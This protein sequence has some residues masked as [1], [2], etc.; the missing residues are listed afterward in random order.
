MAC[1]QVDDFMLA[2]A[3][4]VTDIYKNNKLEHMLVALI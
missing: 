2:G 4:E 3:R 1:I